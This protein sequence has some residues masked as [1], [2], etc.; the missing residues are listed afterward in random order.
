MSEMII[1][2]YDALLAAGAP[3]EKA[4]AAATAVAGIKDEPGRRKVAVELENV[5]GT[6]RLHS[7]I[8]TTNTAM[9]TA[10]LFKL[11]S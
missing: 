1:E 5:R 10:I 8:L 7:W 11:F 6:Q 2:V 4:R 3:E 9:L